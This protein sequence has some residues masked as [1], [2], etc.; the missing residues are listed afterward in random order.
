MY[1][2]Q[3]HRF[4]LQSLYCRSDNVKI[5]PINTEPILIFENENSNTNFINDGS[6]ERFSE[7]VESSVLL[8]IHKQKL[9]KNLQGNISIENKLQIINSEFLNVKIFDIFAG[10]LMKN[11]DF[12]FSESD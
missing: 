11:S 9:L 12:S 10:G 5:E 7:N 2:K 1:S 8:N 4:T 6:D 3:Y